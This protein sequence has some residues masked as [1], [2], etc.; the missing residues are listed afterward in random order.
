MRA[1]QHMSAKNDSN[2][3]PRRLWM[4]YEGKDF[5]AI[6]E[7]YN[8]RPKCLADYVELIPV[9]ISPADYHELLAIDTRVGPCT[10]S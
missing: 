7:G 9:N 10:T 6:D 5:Y 8:G 2:G 4:V 3:N 1:Y